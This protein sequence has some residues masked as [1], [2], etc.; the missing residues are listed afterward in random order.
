MRY[1]R[2]FNESKDWKIWWEGETG[3]SDEELQEIVDTLGDDE[4]DILSVKCFPW[5][6]FDGTNYFD[7]FEINIGLKGHWGMGK[8][9]NYI[10][11]ERFPIEKWRNWITEFLSKYD[12]N[13]DYFYHTSPPSPGIRIIFS[14]KIPN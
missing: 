5:G 8:Q 13:L 12:F 1:L 11:K 10:T 2:K 7:S 3:I 4:L 6:K 14:R 9:K